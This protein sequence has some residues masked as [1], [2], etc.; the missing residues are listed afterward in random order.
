MDI[1]KQIRLAMI[2]ME[3]QIEATTTEVLKTRYPRI[4]PSNCKSR[5]SQRELQN[6]A[7]NDIGRHRPCLPEVLIHTDVVAVI[8]FY[9]STTGRKAHEEMPPIMQSPCEASIGACKN[10]GRRHAAR[11]RNDAGGGTKTEEHS[12]ELVK[13]TKAN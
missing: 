10:N 7:D 9:S 6:I 13:A 5:N 12:A 4:T 8:A 1:G 2:S 11:R 3:K